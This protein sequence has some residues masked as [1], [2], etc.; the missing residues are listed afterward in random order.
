[1]AVMRT[2]FRDLCVFRHAPKKIVNLDFS[3]TF[4]ALDTV[5]STRQPLVWMT[6]LHETEKRLTSNSSARMALERFFLKIIPI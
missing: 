3:D 5:I 2:F 1:M 4:Q 6:E